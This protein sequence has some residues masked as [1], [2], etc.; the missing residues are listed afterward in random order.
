MTYRRLALVL[1]PTFAFACS[2]GGAVGRPPVGGS[3]TCPGC[4]PGGSPNPSPSP[5]PNIPAASGGCTGSAAAG[6]DGK[7]V[8]E[9]LSSFGNAQ[10]DR[11]FFNEVQTQESWWSNIAPASVGLYRE[12]SSGNAL[13]YDTGEIL[14]GTGL[15]HKLISR[16]G[17][18]AVEVVLAHEWGHQ[19]QYALR[20]DVPAVPSRTIELEADAFAGFYVGWIRD[21]GQQMLATILDTVHSIGDEEYTNPYHHGT[22]VERKYMA[23]WGYAQ[24]K[25]AIQTGITPTWQGLHDAAKRELSTMAVIRE[26]YGQ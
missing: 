19:V 18:T 1:V 5:G 16:F 11:A 6:V 7:D 9:I 25:S 24:A 8:C 26:L 20:F 23:L 21:P 3:D 15:Y 12:C 14:F 2:S 10:D 13:S 4:P 22:P 17:P